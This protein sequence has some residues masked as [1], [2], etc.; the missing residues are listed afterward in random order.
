MY[1]LT[2]KNIEIYTDG[3]CKGNPGPGGW[4]AILKYNNYKKE[5]SGYESMTTN[6]RMELLAV[7]EALKLIK[8]PCN[9]II[10]SDSQY[11]CKAIG[12]KWLLK[13]QNNNW[14]KNKKEAVAN[15]DL[16]KTYLNLSKIHNINI[17][18]IK[19]H[20]G[21]PENELCDKLAVNQIKNN[22]QKIRI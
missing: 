2:L 7:I 4:G 10:F 14:M 11:V 22:I 9:I 21:H 1:L 13:W 16:W 15:S 19:G 8:E 3:A 18:W 5:I 6:N 17:N 12:E 20:A